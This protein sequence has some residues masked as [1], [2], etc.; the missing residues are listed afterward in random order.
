MLSGYAAGKKEAVKRDA[1][2]Q[3]VEMLLPT[4]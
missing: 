1:N 2:A 4:G 3:V